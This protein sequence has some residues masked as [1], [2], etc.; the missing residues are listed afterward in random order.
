MVGTLEGPGLA[1]A[2]KWSSA[3]LGGDGAGHGVII[4]LQGYMSLK[5]RVLIWRN[6]YSLC[7]SGYFCRVKPRQENPFYILMNVCIRLLAESRVLMSC[8]MLWFP[9]GT[10]FGGGLHILDSS[11]HQNH[12]LSQQPCSSHCQFIGTLTSIEGSVDNMP[13]V[14]V[15]EWHITDEKDCF[16]MNCDGMQSSYV[17]FSHNTSNFFSEFLLLPSS[18]D[19][20][21]KKIERVQEL[22][23]LCV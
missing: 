16:S 15:I 13:E 9:V 12:L 7:S 20:P 4:F 1:V 21:L 5:T 11:N 22:I 23:F 8:S 3:P 17:W 10:I 18:H 6:K 2:T 14:S 19:I